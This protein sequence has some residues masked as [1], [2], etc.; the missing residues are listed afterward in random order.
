VT[1]PALVTGV[2]AIAANGTDT[3][4]WWRATLDGVSGIRPLSRFDAAG[5][6]LRLAGEAVDFVAADHVEGRLIAQTDRWT[7]FAL[8]AGDRALADAD[9]DPAELPAYQLAVVTASSS[10]G[11]E[12]G[13]LEIENLWRRGP[14]Y[15]GPY[16]SIAWFYAATTGQ[17][18]I[19]H[20]MK[21]ECGVVVAEQAGGLDSIGQARRVLR[22]G[23][24]AVLTGGTEAPIGPYATT[25][26][27]ASGLLSESTDPQRAY[28]PF[29]PEAA[30]HV[31]GEGGAI[32][33][34]ESAGSVRDR[35]P[36]R[37]YGEIAGYAATF[38]PTPDT[39]PALRRAIERALADAMLYPHEIDVVFADAAAV[40]DR[41]AEEAAVLV[42][43]FGPYGVPVTAP[44][45][46]VGRLYAGG[47]ALDVA[48]ALLAIRDDVVPPTP[49]PDAA[50][51]YELDLVT[52]ARERQV[53]T[54]LVLAR[55]YGGFT[56]AL[57][58]R[59]P[60]P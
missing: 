49:G 4:T 47:S 40:P 41:D 36:P 46:L 3:E 28:L 56:S 24:R 33:V 45:T 38:A 29:Q 52:T 50:P 37:R 59:E 7:Q 58:V 44:K 55:G 19:R 13:Q 31:P 6:P 27:L 2:A 25:C 35:R 43:L 39:R 26:Q 21:G 1:A 48:A 17:L 51:Y 32:L 34:L 60:L 8:A 18:S 20:G 54:A 10:G 9:L 42:E 16:Q 53:R 15:V 57:V 30:G 11:N 22:R 14:E 23:A 12:F 5:Y